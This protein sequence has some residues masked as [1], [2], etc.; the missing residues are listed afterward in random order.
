MATINELQQAGSMRHLGYYLA[1]HLM[2]ISL[3]VTR[4]MKFGSYFGMQ[5]KDTSLLEQVQ[6]VMATIKQSHP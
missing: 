1:L 5:T 6:Q 2:T 3:Q 4:V